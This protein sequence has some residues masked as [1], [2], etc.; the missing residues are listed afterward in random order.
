[1]SPYIKKL[2]KE[3]GKSEKEVEKLWTKAKEI[4]G[5]E[6]GKSEK[7]FGSKEFAYTTSIVKKM[8]GVDESV[9]DPSIFLESKQSAKSYLEDVVT[10]S[11]FNIG[12][13]IP[14]DEEEE[15]EEKQEE[16][17]EITELPEKAKEILSTIQEDPDDNYVKM[18]DSLLEE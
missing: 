7:D 18:L 12:N 2:S 13:V 14:P 16:K 11:S 10:S 6:F 15:D 1:M 9:L 5:E 3:T 17:A 4:T 8:L